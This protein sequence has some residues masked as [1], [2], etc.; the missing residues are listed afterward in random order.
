MGIFLFMGGGGGQGLVFNS[1]AFTNYF[2]PREV[3]ITRAF[4][5]PIWTSPKMGC[6]GKWKPG[7]L[8]HTH[9][10]AQGRMGM[11]QNQTTRIWTTGLPRFHL[12]FGSF[13]SF[14]L[15]QSFANRPVCGPRINRG[16][17]KELVIC[18]FRPRII[19]V[20]EP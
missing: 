8:S 11:G 2:G 14:R 7:P 6:P 4:F 5:N 18:R 13:P 10:Q 3:F 9:L 15:P 16:S 19:R 20:V 12:P 17:I 1:G